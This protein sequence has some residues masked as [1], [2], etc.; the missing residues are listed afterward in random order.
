MPLLVSLQEFPQF[1]SGNYGDGNGVIVHGYPGGD[2]E[3]SSLQTKL[4][5]RLTSHFTMLGGFTWAKLITDDGNPPLGFVGSHLGRASGLE[6][7]SNTSTRSAPRTST[8]FTGQ[9]SYDLPFGKDRAVN[10]HGVR[11]RL[12]RRVDN[13]RHLLLEQRYSDC[14]ARRRS[15][16][17]LL[18]PAAESHLQPGRQRAAHSNAWFNPDCF[19]FPATNSCRNRSRLSGRCAPW[20]QTTW[21]CPSTRFQIRKPRTIRIE[22][23]SYNVA[24]R[25][26]FGMPVV[27][28]LTNARYRL[29]S[30]RSGFGPSGQPSTH[31]ASFSSPRGSR[32]DTTTPASPL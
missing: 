21:I 10:L 23:S 2:S 27:P 24:N 28:D 5:K 15:P 25:P 1:G 29:G 30:R 6:R 32:S 18:Q 3:Y 26:Q 12:P 31:H 16:L 4:Q 20:E 8:Q 11:K 13:K 19:A 9:A 14:L 22:V 17:L 7:T